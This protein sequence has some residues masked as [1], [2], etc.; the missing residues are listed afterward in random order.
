MTKTFFD[1]PFWVPLMALIVG[2]IYAWIL[3]AK[4]KSV[5]SI[6]I[7][8]MLAACRFLAVAVL[9]FM[10]LA[11]MLRLLQNESIAPVFLFAI[12]NSA[13]IEL[14]T[15]EEERDELHDRL[16]QLASAAESQ[17]AR[18][19]F[20]NFDRQESEANAFFDDLAYAHPNTNLNRYLKEIERQFEGRNLA[21]LVLVSDG[22]YN[23]G[24]SPLFSNFSF[25]IHSVALGDSSKMRDVGIK[26]VFYNKIAYE[27]NKFPVRVS[28]A[29]Y[30][31]DNRQLK[32]VARR[33]AERIEEQEVQLG[34][35][36]E[37]MEV[38]FLFTANEKGLQQYT[39]EL[40]AQE[41]EK[42]LENN[43]ATAYIEVIEGKQ[44]I[45]IAAAA[46]HPDIKAINRA[47]SKNEN[48]EVVLYTPGVN[49]WESQDFDLYILHQMSRKELASKPG[50]Q[51]S[52]QADKAAWFY[53][54]GSRSNLAHISEENHLVSIQTVGGD[55]DRV[56]PSPATS[57]DL[58]RLPE[59]LSD[60]TRDYTPIRVPYGKIETSS[61]AKTLLYQ[62]IGSVTTN[63]PL[64]L[65]GETRGA[66]QAVL[67]GS[68]IWQ[69]RLQEFASMQSQDNFDQ[70]IG[71]SVQYLVTQD[72]KRRFRVYPTQNEFIEGEEVK[73]V[74]ETYDEIYDEVYG[75]GVDLK[76][77]GPEG[78]QF[79]YSFTTAAGGLR[80]PIAGLQEGV[81]K[82]QASAEGYDEE[83]GEFVVKKINLE[84][85]DLE[86]RWDL[87]AQLSEQSGGQFVPPDRLAELEEQLDLSKTPAVIFSEEN[88]TE[89]IHLK[90]LFFVLLILLSVEWIVR[91]YSGAY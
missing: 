85:L 91:K 3:Y 55:T 83:S 60:A 62:R 37:L 72:D 74:A 27:G 64:F 65:I 9:V 86:A 16:I 75:V 56:L 34:R 32:I 18:V 35:S 28:I 17:G 19:L 63:K 41:E 76:I 15:S 44:K 11:P 38:E 24:A 52:K 45:L 30:G 50:V 68:G 25:P 48:Y 51:L 53:I 66:K 58:F 49:E 88:Y 33:G 4:K 46:P 39:F 23:V 90:S 5:W 81:Y 80:F 26:E 22:I 89:I 70:L 77:A 73:F 87:L 13:S 21:Q 69:W 36:D 84:A 42:N 59:K 7:N 29:Q 14:Q 10:L 47:I 1:T 78:Q 6:Q 31:Y 57:F 40:E 12:D 61:H 20:T 8:Y 43:R 54:I 67:L 2:F 79:E 82:Y 71:R